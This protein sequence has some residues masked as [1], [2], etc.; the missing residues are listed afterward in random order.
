MVANNV[1]LRGS[2]KEL[3]VD[4]G[5]HGEGFILKDNP[6]SLWKQKPENSESRQN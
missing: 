3:I 4:L 5:G 2:L 1:M 6:G